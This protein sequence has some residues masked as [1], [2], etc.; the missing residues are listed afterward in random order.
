MFVVALLLCVAPLAS[1]W[2]EGRSCGPPLPIERE[3]AVS[4]AVF[5]GTII[6]IEVQKGLEVIGTQTVAT[7][8]VENVWKGVSRPTMQ[9]ATPGGGNVIFSTSLSFK[10]GERYVVFAS[11][12]FP[13]SISC[14][15]TGTKAHYLWN[16]T[17]EWLE[18][19]PSKP[20]G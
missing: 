7:F 4:S 11:G 13:S 3:F 5:I 6:E 8:S 2:A 17:I 18:R 16:D 15:R 19:Q 14:G 1:D 9:V 10:L 12:P 20:A